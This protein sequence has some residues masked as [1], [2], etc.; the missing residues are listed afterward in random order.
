MGWLQIYLGFPCASDSKESACSARDQGPTPGLGGSP[1]E[2][3]GY[4]LQYPC[5]EDPMDRGAMGL[6]S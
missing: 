2:A 5:L 4:S 3:N 1:G 6:Q